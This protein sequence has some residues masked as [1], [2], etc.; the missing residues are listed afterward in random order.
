VI[1]IPAAG[2]SASFITNFNPGDNATECA[3]T[4]TNFDFG[5]T[6]P[7]V[8]YRFTVAAPTEIE[9]TVDWD[10]DA[11]LDTYACG[12]ADPSATGDCFEDGG[13]GATGAHPQAFTFTFPAGTH[14]LVVENYDG[15][16]TRNIYVTARRP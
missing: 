4:A 1:T 11:D 9:F 7:C 10:S 12:S 16:A 2:E 5:S 3:E 13:A 14:Y 6:G 8:I 15:I